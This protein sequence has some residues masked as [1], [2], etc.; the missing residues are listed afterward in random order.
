MSV[1][2]NAGDLDREITLVTGVKTQDS[3]TGE[4]VIVWD[5]DAGVTVWAQW[6][7][8]GTREQWQS[9]QRLGSYVEGVWKIYAIEP[10]PTAAGTRILSEGRTYDVRGV[11]EIGR[12]E[13]YEL[14]VVARADGAS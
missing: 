1:G 14:A 10:A 4:E 12:S 7:P 6:L 13:G 3:G 2:L 8:G 11:T 5:V 9:Q